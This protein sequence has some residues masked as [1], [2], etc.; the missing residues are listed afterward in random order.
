MTWI[1]TCN[2][3]KK[4]T[5]Y[6]LSSV[7]WHHTRWDKLHP[8]VSRLVVRIFSTPPPPARCESNFESRARN[9]SHSWAYLCPSMAAIIKQRTGCSSRIKPKILPKNRWQHQVL[10]FTDFLP[11]RSSFHVRTGWLSSQTNAQNMEIYKSII[12][13]HERNFDMYST[14][15]F[16]AVSLWLQ[17]LTLLK[18]SPVAIT[19]WRPKFKVCPAMVVSFYSK[20]KTNKVCATYAQSLKECTQMCQNTLWTKRKC[21]VFSKL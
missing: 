1:S 17:M 13:V 16:T 7:G 20:K 2:L 21:A 6:K 12:V 15:T 9:V 19:L 10:G 8:H 3:H 5:G 11:L 14:C 18:K 4:H